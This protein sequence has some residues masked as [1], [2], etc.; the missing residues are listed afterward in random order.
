MLRQLSDLHFKLRQLI[1]MITSLLTIREISPF[2]FV[3]YSPEEAHSGP[4]QAPKDK[5]S[6]RRQKGESQN[7]CFKKTK[8]ARFSKKQ[9][10]PTP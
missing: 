6:V 8:H 10:F 1:K 4:I 3:L 9:T 7:G 5:S 2:E